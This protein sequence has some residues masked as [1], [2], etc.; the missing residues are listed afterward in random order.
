MISVSK[1]KRRNWVYAM[2]FIILIIGIT[3][4]YIAQKF[5]GER[6]EGFFIQFDTTNIHGVIKDVGIGYHG[7]VFKIK[8]MNKEF[9]FYPYT[10]KI[11]EYK[12]FDHIAK[13][14][15]TII[16]PPYSDTLTLLKNGK[17]YLYTFD[18]F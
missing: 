13:E 5:G 16:K 8:G 18:K 11:N 4:S 3:Y 15:D 6:E 17:E 9:V 7:A 2:I 14:G 1:V 10:G 12:I